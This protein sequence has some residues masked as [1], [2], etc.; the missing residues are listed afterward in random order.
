[1]PALMKRNFAEMNPVRMAVAGLVLLLVAA[2]LALNSGAIIRHFTTTTYKA[3]FSDAGGLAPGNNVEISGVVMGTVKSVDLESDGYVQVTFDVKHGGHL[4]SM[5]GARIGSSTLLGTKVIKLASDGTGTLAPGSTIPLSRTTSP[6]DLAQV[7]STLT[8]QAGQVNAGQLATAFNT[9]AATLKNAP[10]D[11]RSALTGIEGLS[12]SISS[13]DAA[14]TQ[15]TRVSDQVTRVLAQR[16]AQVRE[17]ITSGNQILATLYQR[18]TDIRELLASVT[19][20]A[21]QLKGLVA[22]NER[23][24]G[25]TLSHLERALTTLKKNDANITSAI[26]G[27]YRYMGS[28]GETLG[29]GPWFYAY[30]ANLVPTNMVGMLPTLF[31]K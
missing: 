21:D 16:T 28:L 26:S 11:L 14:L 20:V 24:I 4:G 2:L 13:R 23:Q 27:L 9:I 15:L 31:G 8:S 22:D 17:L 29:S 12:K 10:P 3:D 7:L 6:Y 1:M 30:V 5:T 25:P 18:R 19:A